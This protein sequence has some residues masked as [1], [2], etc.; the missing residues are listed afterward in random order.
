MAVI[1]NKS[2]TLLGSILG[3]LIVGNFHLEQ[4]CL[5]F[6][7]ARLLVGFGEGKCLLGRMR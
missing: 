6:I 1:E 3:L 2:P 7:Q 4:R 5:Q